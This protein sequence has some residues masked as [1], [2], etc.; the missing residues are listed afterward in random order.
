MYVVRAQ[1]AH[2]NSKILMTRS[3]ENNKSIFL[4]VSAHRHLTKPVQ[5][6][7]RQKLKSEKFNP[8]S[9]WISNF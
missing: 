7:E 8:T 1:S 4:S 2:K 5:R 3:I 9:S 6:Y